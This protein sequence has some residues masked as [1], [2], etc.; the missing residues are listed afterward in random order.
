[1]RLRSSWTRVPLT[2]IAAVT[3]ASCGKSSI[4][5]ADDLFTPASGTHFP[6]TSALVLVDTA[7]LKGNAACYTVGGEAPGLDDD[8]NCTG[9]GSQSVG[10]S[11][12]LRCDGDTDDETLRQIKLAFLW[13]DFG[14][15][16]VSA[17]YT[18]DCSS[19]TDPGDGGVSPGAPDASGNGWVNDDM[20]RAVVRTLDQ[21]R[22]DIRCSDPTG[23]GEV[24]TIDCEGG[25]TASWYVDLDIL[26]GSAD[27]TLTYDE[28]SY[29][30]EEG[31]HLT[32]DGQLFQLSNLA[33]DGEERGTV[34]VS[35]DF[36]G[37][38]TS[39]H[40]FHGRT[41][42][43]GFVTISCTEHARDDLGSDVCAPNNLATKHPFPD[44]ECEGN[45]CP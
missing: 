28:C 41:R 14:Q 27:S 3:L 12:P 15:Q 2:V 11:I 23:G 5:T 16:Q 36:T 20:A 24:G 35:G 18:L 42:D 38:Y 45:E 29:V 30:S 4:P 32:I 8:G 21:I 9:A 40:V 31:D 39:S 34:D 43:G 17:T 25:G 1:M 10:T 26:A 6:R 13:P 37:N 19:S 7:R 22:C 44:Y 33:G